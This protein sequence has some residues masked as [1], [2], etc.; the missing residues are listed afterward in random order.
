M[1]GLKGDEAWQDSAIALRPM[2][3]SFGDGTVRFP[4]PPRG[5]SQVIG[6]KYKV[7]VCECVS[8]IHLLPGLLG[9]EPET[10]P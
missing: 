2:K 5:L 9:I 4:K 3:S 8:Q 7:L 10:S 1:A 6:V